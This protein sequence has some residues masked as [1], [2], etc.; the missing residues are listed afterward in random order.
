[1]TKLSYKNETMKS[2]VVVLK[3]DSCL[4]VRRNNKT[5]WAPGEERGRWSSVEAWRATLPAGS[6]PLEETRTKNIH[7][8]YN[9]LTDPILRK[10][11]SAV[12]VNIGEYTFIHGSSYKAGQLRKDRTGSMQIQHEIYALRNLEWGLQQINEVN[13]ARSVS[14]ESVRAR[15]IVLN[16]KYNEIIKGFYHPGW[17]IMSK[18]D[19]RY[20]D[21]RFYLD[22]GAGKM[23]S[24]FWNTDAQIVMVWIPARG[25][26]PIRELGRTEDDIMN[27]IWHSP[28]QK[29]GEPSIYRV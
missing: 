21:T 1:M 7:K 19:R 3:D 17:F 2:S 15:L 27:S 20:L 8:D 13:V 22:D 29:K 12:I 11:L 23:Y 4:E 16:K 25:L 9:N 26:V 24:I 14:L 28:L 18:K 6:T 5:T 10:L